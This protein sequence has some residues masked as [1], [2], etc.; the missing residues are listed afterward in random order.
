MTWAGFLLSL[1]GPLAKRALA[2]LGLGVITYVGVASAV[3]AALSAAAGAFAGAGAELTAI[4]AIAGVFD[5]LSISIG[6]V[7]S[8][9]A[10]MALKRF[11]VLG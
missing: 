8:G 10:F 4:L 1:A 3:D 2:S 9:I 11:G 7:V 6:G 5:S